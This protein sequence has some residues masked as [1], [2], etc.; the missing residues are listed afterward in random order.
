MNQ[1]NIPTVRTYREVRLLNGSL[2]SIQ[3]D[4]DKADAVVACLMEHVVFA[5]I[6]GGKRV[7]TKGSYGRYTRYDIV[8]H[9]YA[10]GGHP[11]NGGFIEALEIRDPPNERC[12]FVLYAVHQVP[13]GLEQ[14]FFVEFQSLEDL[15]SAYK[16]HW[17]H[18]HQ[19]IQSDAP[20]FPGF[21]RLVPCGALTP[22]FYA[23]GHQE[24]HRDFV[25]VPEWGNDPMYPPGKQFVV[26]PKGGC[27]R[28]K[29]CMG[30]RVLTD[31]HPNGNPEDVRHYVL[32]DDGTCWNGHGTPPKA[33][34][35][36][37]W[38]VETLDEEASVAS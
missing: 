29:T 18:N 1:K 5:E 32:W 37:P 16:A 33:S 17:G 11:G 28:T 19:R 34:K 14:G 35:T 25:I 31:H 2:L 3:V 27:S 9:H 6:G 15:V 36:Q 20:A 8:Q 24:L 22:W 38:F 4:D 23:V 26:T 10:G 30:A 21:L 7:V 12:R 13:F